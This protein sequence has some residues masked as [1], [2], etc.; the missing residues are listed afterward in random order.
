MEIRMSA[1]RDTLARVKAACEKAQRSDGSVRVIAV[2][3]L[4]PF[5][6]IAGL[7]RAEGQIDFGENYVQ[8]LTGKIAEADAAG[9]RDLRWHLIGPLQKNK[10]NAVIGRGLLMHALDSV[11]TLEALDKRAIGT[12]QV[13]LQVNVAG[14]TS[15]HGFNPDDVLKNWAKISS[16]E[17][18]RVR[19]LMTMP[20]LQNEPEANRPHYRALSRLQRELRGDLTE[21]SSPLAEL[22]MGTSH[23][24]EIAI[25]EGATL[26][27]LGT[28]LFGARPSR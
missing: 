24:F 9:L 16:L 6:K 7:A 26:L 15:K 8:E 14:E 10:I 1:Y 21:L 2:S 5:E 19:G 20:P 12:E 18:V 25:E 22:S 23:D 27:R 11:S 17:K 3:K 28:V 4:Q 13:L